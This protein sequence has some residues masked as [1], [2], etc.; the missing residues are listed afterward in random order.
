[1]LDSYKAADIT[2][3]RK[4]RQRLQEKNRSKKLRCDFGPSASNTG[5]PKDKQDRD[6]FFSNPLIDVL[7][8]FQNNEC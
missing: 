4:I 7:R 5:E 6:L 1:M 3:A 8:Y 2:L